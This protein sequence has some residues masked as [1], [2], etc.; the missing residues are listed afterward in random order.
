VPDLLKGALNAF[1]LP[2]FGFPNNRF[3]QY[4]YNSRDQI[5]EENKF[6]AALLLLGGIVFSENF[7]HKYPNYLYK[8]LRVLKDI[9]SNQQGN[10]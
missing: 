1:W 2:S 9:F 4:R 5:Q 8:L 10:T 7:I 6:S 3:P